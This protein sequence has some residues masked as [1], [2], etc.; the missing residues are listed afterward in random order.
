[1][2]LLDLI[3]STGSLRAIAQQVGLSE[4]QAR[5]AAGALLPALVGGFKKQADGRSG[6]D[7]LVTMLTRSGGGGLFDNVVSPQPTDSG[8]GNNVLANIFGS[9]DVSREVATQAAQ[10]TGLSFDTLKKMLPLLAMV[11]AG[12]LSK[13][14]NNSHGG[15]FLD[16]LGDML[17]SQDGGLSGM[18]DLDGN[19]NPLDDLLR[20]AGKMFSR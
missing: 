20:A 16:Q 9:K 1:M 15:G 13:Q 11:A 10:Q 17:G 18:I 3:Q 7:G 14:A 4:S 5:T 19:G 6:I 8:L 2:Q 12:L